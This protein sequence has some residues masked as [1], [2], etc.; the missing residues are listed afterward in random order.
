MAKL[1]VPSDI[2]HPLVTGE[3]LEWVELVNI[4]VGVSISNQ[5]REA[6]LLDEPRLHLQ[7]TIE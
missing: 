7:N 1:W 6:E 2:L 4:F 5:V 3:H